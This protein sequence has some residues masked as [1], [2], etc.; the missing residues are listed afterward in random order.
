MC[1][2]FTVYLLSIS[3]NWSCEYA[4]HYLDSLQ[5]CANLDAF[6]IKTK[7]LEEEEAK[8]PFKRIARAEE[9]KEVIPLNKLHF[10]TTS[11]GWELLQI[12]KNIYC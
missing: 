8:T 5:I 3:L 9:R 6:T 4:S 12:L 2:G 10:C 1:D 11:L 7:T